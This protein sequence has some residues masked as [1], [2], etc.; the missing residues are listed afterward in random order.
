MDAIE[1]STKV[2]LTKSSLLES[3]VN[4][5]KVDNVLNVNEL[6]TTITAAAEPREGK[7]RKFRQR[8]KWGSK[9][10]FILACM[11]YAIGLGNVWRFPYLCYKNGGGKNTFFARKCS[12]AIISEA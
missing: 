1:N 11:A 10:E 7:E 9:V 12:L 8:E 2:T 6:N 5:K 4:D 3:N